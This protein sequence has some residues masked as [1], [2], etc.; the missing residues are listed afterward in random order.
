MSVVGEKREGFLR[1]P[2]LGR[3]DYIELILR[4]IPTFR[5]GNRLREFLWV[6]IPRL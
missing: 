5:R 2:L 4:V 6:Q 3:L 1:S